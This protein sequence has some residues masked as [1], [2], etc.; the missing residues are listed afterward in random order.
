MRALFR[1]IFKNHFVFLFLLL[2]GISFIF[3]IQFN[4]FQKSRFMEYSRNVSSYIYTNLQSFREYFN[5]RTRNDILNTENARL[6]NLIESLESIERDTAIIT[7]NA[8]RINYIY[9][10]ARV[11]NNT[12]NKQNNYL[13]VNKGRLQGVYPEM[14]VIS[15]QGVVGIVKA[16]SDNFATVLPVLNRDFRLSAKNK[17]NNYFGIIEWDGRSVESVKL[18]EIPIHIDIREGD[19]IVTSGYSAIFPEG[20]PVGIVETVS[21]SDENFHEV[22]VKLG[23]NFRNLVHVN[24]VRYIYKDEQESL[25]KESGL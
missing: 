7:N 16:T 17:R 1:F 19:T 21:P 22:K 2:E 18:N 13:T 4:D 14:A 6:R 5:L 15:D 25:E 11:I 12:I 3:I 24:L 20:I 10:P 8:R 9:T 23:T